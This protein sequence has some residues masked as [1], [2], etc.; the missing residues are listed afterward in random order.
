MAVE[1][2]EDVDLALADALGDLLGLGEAESVPT[3]GEGAK[4][5]G[6]GVLDRACI[7]AGDVHAIAVG[8]LEEWLDEHRDDMIPEVAGEESDAK[9][10]ACNS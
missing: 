5:S 1:F 10:T 4:V 3:I 7:E 9:R 2:D 6:D 8:V